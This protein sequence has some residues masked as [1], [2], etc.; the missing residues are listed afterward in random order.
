MPNELDT[1]AMVMVWDNHI[2][3]KVAPIAIKY[4]YE[5][6]FKSIYTLFRGQTRLPLSG[7]LSDAFRLRKL[8]S[9]HHSVW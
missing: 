6:L 8:C 5:N 3:R 2:N 9:Y 1:R 4:L 7:Y